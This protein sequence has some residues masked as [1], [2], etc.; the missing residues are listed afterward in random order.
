M[1]K[2]QVDRLL[3][4][5]KEEEKIILN[6]FMMTKKHHRFKVLN[7]TE[8]GFGNTYYKTGYVNKNPQLNLTSIKEHP[9]WQ[10]QQDM[11]KIVTLGLQH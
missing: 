11:M 1:G 2:Q 7:K 5:M 8:P 3:L 4:Y 10:L 9:T 6:V